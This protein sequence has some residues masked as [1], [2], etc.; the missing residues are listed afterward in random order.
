M[1][2][3]TPKARERGKA[4][5]SRVANVYNER[6]KA[7][8]KEMEKARK[9]RAKEARRQLEKRMGQGEDLAAGELPIS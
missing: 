4:C 1:A 2:K 7:Q 6:Q 8:A 9:A 3:E 5:A